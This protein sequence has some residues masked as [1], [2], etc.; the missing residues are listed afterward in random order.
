[1]PCPHCDSRLKY[2]DSCIRYIKAEGGKNIRLL[3]RR[4][5]CIRCKR[6]HRE[7]P[8]SIVPFKH[9]SAEVIS[10]VLDGVIRAEDLDTEDYPC[11]KTMDRWQQWFSINA[12]RIDG[13]L[14]SITYRLLGF[15]EELLLSSVSLLQH[16]R[17][18]CKHW[19][20]RIIRTIYNSGGSLSS[21]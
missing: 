15:N 7:L 8:D 14:K 17:S 10:G 1:M 12:Q 19:L 21:G 6:L 2:R 9:Y 4:L 13:Y 18:S 3:I 11:E 5:K 20:E 16:M